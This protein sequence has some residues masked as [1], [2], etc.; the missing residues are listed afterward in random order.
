[1]LPTSLSH[2]SIVRPSSHISFTCASKAALVRSFLSSHSLTINAQICSIGF[3]SGQGFGGASITG[4]F[5]GERQTMPSQHDFCAR[6]NYPGPSWRVRE[7]FKFARY[8]IML[9]WLTDPVPVVVALQKK[10]NKRRT[11]YSKHYY[12]GVARA[13]RGKGLGMIRGLGTS[14]SKWG[15]GEN[16]TVCYVWACLLQ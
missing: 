14:K 6:G 10:S 12:R 7:V 8:F 5:E 2:I 15:K 16:H 11:N 1:M 3:I 13:D 9:A 4:W